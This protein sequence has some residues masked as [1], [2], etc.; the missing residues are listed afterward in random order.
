MNPRLLKL[1]NR[2]SLKTGMLVVEGEDIVTKARSWIRG[3]MMTHKKRIA[4]ETEEN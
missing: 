2:T 4:A 3:K 1:A